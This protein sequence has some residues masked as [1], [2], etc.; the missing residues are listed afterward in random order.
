MGIWLIGLLTFLVAS[1]TAAVAG[2]NG[3]EHWTYKITG[4][5]YN[6]T[7]TL[8][9]GRLPGGC[10]GIALWEGN[11]STNN[12]DEVAPLTLGKMALT[13][14]AHG[15]S[16]SGLAKIQV[17]SQLSNAF[18]RE[19][20]ACDESE[21]ETAFK[22]TPCTGS[23]ESKMHLSMKIS[24][25][26]GTR[27]SLLWDFFQFGGATGTLVTD[28]FSCVEPFKFPDQTCTT[29][30]SLG[31][32]NHNRVSLP[33]KCLYSTQSPPPGSMYTKYESNAYAKGVVN[34]KRTN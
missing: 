31:A 2:E 21:S 32:L 1:P 26:V 12:D 13:I 30:S 8:A 23:R 28:S 25:G 29:K 24:G 33:F 17:K 16:G 15:T 19:T 10:V 34:L 27:V 3:T 4:V 9:G 20:T 11:V 6:A 14:H 5:D 18:H 22:M 7:G